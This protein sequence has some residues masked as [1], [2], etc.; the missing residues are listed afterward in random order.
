MMQPLISVLMSAYDEPIE[1]VCQAV[2]SIVEQTY[3][4]LEFLIV[5][6]KPDNEVLINFL[7]EC[8]EKDQRIKLMINQ[9]NIG[10]ARSLNQAL[11]AASG[12]YIA[13]M[14]AD[15]ISKPERLEKELDFLCS[16]QLDVVGCSA[17][18][19]DENGKVWGEIRR[20]S[21]KPEA[22]KRLL[23]VQNVI[24][25]PSI[26]TKQEVV[27]SV[28]GY[29][30]FPSCQ[31]YDLWLRLLSRGYVFGVTEEILFQFRRHPNSITA[32][33]R[34][35][36]FLNE[37]YIRK[38]HHERE[39]N[40][41]TDSFSE[42][43][44]GKYLTSKGFYDKA[45]SDKHNRMLIKYNRGISDIKKKK[46]VHG[47][48]EVAASLGSEAVRENIRISVKSKKIRREYAER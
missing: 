45:I 28:G 24:V 26:I 19:I 12:K 17:E 23:P 20:Y 16:N 39:M 47:I 34:Y 29:R 43:E 30:N 5:C 37:A 48:V 6:D 35:G 4:N 10:L 8:A 27:R 7:S 18:K 1:Y 11:A 38:L 40:G 21:D 41:G 3:K 2:S 31:D 22:Y 25:H 15:D 46:Y 33:R 13:R 9:E 44:F 14:D 42:E 36:Q 32:T